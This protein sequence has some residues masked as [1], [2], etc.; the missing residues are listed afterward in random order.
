M[1]Y[2][3][4]KKMNRFERGLLI[5]LLFCTVLSTL[6][7]WIIGDPY[8]P[9]TAVTA[10]LILY[11]ERGHVGSIRYGLRRIATQIIQGFLVALCILLCKVWLK[12]PIPDPILIIFSC[13]FALLVGLPI[14]FHYSFAPLNC[15]LAN[16]TFILATSFILDYTSY[17]MRVLHCIAGLLIGYFV[18]YVVESRDH[19]CDDFLRSVKDCLDN[20]NMTL[21]RLSKQ[22]DT[23]RNTYRGWKEDISSGLRQSEGLSEAIQIMCIQI[24]ILSVI[25]E[26]W[27]IR[28]HFTSQVKNSYSLQTERMIHDCR[29]RHVSMLETMMRHEPLSTFKTLDIEIPSAPTK[30]EISLISPVIMYDRLLYESSSLYTS[31][32]NARRKMPFS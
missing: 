7:S 17:P 24:Q 30:G 27:A 31:Q 1:V 4:R 3:I 25:E 18:L 9:T 22:R 26:Y 28:E 20:P 5:K 21:E 8:S 32:Y 19:A 2:K 14:N 23:L 29:K 10:N 13:C 16:A 11:I 12:L 6:F 15:T